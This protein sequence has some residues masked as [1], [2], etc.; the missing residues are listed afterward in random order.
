MILFPLITGN[1]LLFVGG[2]LDDSIQDLQL[3]G[4]RGSAV[5]QSTKCHFSLDTHC[6]LVL[7]QHGGRFVSGFRLF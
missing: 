5:T 2:I 7:Q 6:E 3:F 4:R 1:W